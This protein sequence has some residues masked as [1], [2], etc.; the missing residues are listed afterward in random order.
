MDMKKLPT[1]S[2]EEGIALVVTLLVVLV[3]GALVTGAVILG[4]NH[5]L[6]DRYWGRQS[7]LVA[8]ADAGLEEARALVNGVKSAYPDDGYNTLESDAT[9]YDGEGQAIPGVTRS[10]YVGPSGITSG[11]FGVFGSIVSVARD[12]GGGV[13][14]RRLQIY[15][16]SFAKFAYFTDSEGGNI[17]FGGGDQIWGPLHT[18]DQIKIHSTRATFH[19]KVTTV[20]DVYQEQYGTFDK[21]YQ[22]YATPVPMPE[23]ADLLEL[24]A[25]A[26]AGG[27]AFSGNTNGA[28]GSATTRIEFV[29]LD[30][31]GD[32]DETD[33]DEGFIRVYQS[34][35]ADW[36]VAKPGATYLEGSRNCG[37]YHDGVFVS[38]ADHVPAVHGHDGKTAL[39]QAS[40]RCYLGGHDSIWG[41][42][43]ANDGIGQWLQWP[44]P[45]DSRVSALRAD[46]NYL[47][48]ISRPLNPSFK[49]VIFVDGKVAVSGKI[50]GRVTVAATGNIIF[51]DDITYVTD[52]GAGTCEDTAGYFSGNEVVM[53]YNPINAPWRP[54][55]YQPYYSYDESAG[56]FF[57]G[58][59]LALAKFT[60]EEYSSGSTSG[61][62]CE[63]NQ[64]GRGCIYLTGGII[65][66]TRGA[67][68]LTSGA[69][70][71]KRYSYDKCAATQPPPYFPTTGVFVKGQYYNVDPAGF[72][73]AQY[74]A[75]IAPI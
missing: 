28:Q 71:I 59:V 40:R 15:E 43:V 55:A 66:D 68:G 16:E 25:Q 20:Q 3:A 31:N 26:A 36:V 2:G 19:D 70:Y 75:M 61:Q 1:R 12:E 24:Q 47:F 23:T 63:G 21:G 8:V 14:I 42:F 4:T 37:D 48:P 73:I 44:G 7:M 22:E 49:G 29:A 34:A 56:E 46:A 62:Y 72:S 35:D 5:M 32:G 67:V 11:Q 58:V 45:V 38:S 27:T 74:F 30:L 33:M 69:G 52:P 60:A 51:A 50:R 57:H 13:A 18:N 64:S 54:Y 9:V 17:Y 65:Q 53:S 41:G 6:V 10:L 39:R